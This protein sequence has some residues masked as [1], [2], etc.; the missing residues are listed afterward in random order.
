[1]WTEYQLG[2]LDDPGA[3]YGRTNRTF[4]W[5]YGSFLRVEGFLNQ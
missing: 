3:L 5:R 4:H 1:V 2:W